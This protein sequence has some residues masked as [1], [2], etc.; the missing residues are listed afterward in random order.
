MENQHIKL[1]N[2]VVPCPMVRFALRKVEACLTCQH[3]GGLSQ[4]VVNGEPINGDEVDI[5]QI[6]CGKPITRR[7]QKVIND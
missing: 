5:Y 2:A 4:A 1:S 3:Y 6:I 7:M